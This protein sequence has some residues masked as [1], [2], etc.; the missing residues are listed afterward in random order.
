MKHPH[1]GSTALVRPPLSAFFSIR[2]SLSSST[3]C[4]NRDQNRDLPRLPLAASDRSR[5]AAY[6]GPR[7]SPLRS[8]SFGSFTLP[9]VRY[10]SH[11][12]QL[13]RLNSKEGGVIMTDL[14]ALVGAGFLL[15]VM[16]F[17]VSIPLGWGLVL[18]GTSLH[19]N[20]F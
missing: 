18:I 9:P 8:T 13:H 10:S 7:L 16:G 12:A 14:R 6:L 4:L 17:V 2:S 3:P 20:G 19:V 1:A 11:R 15:A 5:R